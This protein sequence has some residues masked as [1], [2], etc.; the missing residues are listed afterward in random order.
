MA[1]LDSPA[2]LSPTRLDD[3]GSLLL[4]SFFNMPNAKD[5]RECRLVSLCRRLSLPAT[6]FQKQTIPRFNGRK[7]DLTGSA[8]RV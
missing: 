4:W 1:S 3:H 6:P 7:A 8:G 2:M 5:R